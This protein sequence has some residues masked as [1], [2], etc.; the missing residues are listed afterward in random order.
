VRRIINKKWILGIIGL[1]L[2]L[3]ILKGMLFW[4][5]K[6]KVTVDYVA[7]YNNMARPKNYDPNKNAAEDYQKA[8]D[9]FIRMP[10]QVSAAITRPAL[11]FSS[12]KML[13][14]MK[15]MM[16]PNNIRTTNEISKESQSR[17]IDWPTDFNDSDQNALKQWLASN[18]PAFDYFRAAS[19]K[20]YYG[21]ERYT[22]TEGGMHSVMIPEISYLRD[23]SNAINWNAKKLASETKYESAFYDILACYR[24]GIH[25]CVPTY[26][27]AEQINGSII[28]SWSIA[29]L[30]SI[31]DRVE[32]GP[33]KLRIF[34]D[35]LKTTFDKDDY[36]P[37]FGAEKLHA[38]DI[39][40]QIFVYNKKGTGRPP[41][42]AVGSVISSCGDEDNY[43]I[44]KK[45]LYDCLFGPTTNEMAKIIEEKYA[46][47]ESAIKE[48]PW[49]LYSMDPAFLNKLV[50]P[51]CDDCGSFNLNDFFFPH[52]YSSHNRYYRLKA[53]ERALLAIIAIHRFKLGKGKLPD[54]LDELVAA[55]Y[56]Q[57]LPLDPYSDGALVYRVEGENFT[58][59]SIGENFKDDG[60]KE[61]KNPFDEILFWPVK[62]PEKTVPVDH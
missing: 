43:K 24:V 45:M 34:Q 41:C 52:F 23:M 42:S 10:F 22:K 30:I 3:L 53:Q 60:G 1:L 31:I 4:T 48:T 56:L 57:T 51:R 9:A 29:T 46:A 58:L 33:E 21:L 11:E 14:E 49:R 27:D 59:Y 5:A 35:A 32:I 28:K 55:G 26:L 36:I 20:P 8:F 19:Q 16:D 6:P 50:V 62:R 12:K 44:R 2:F 18:A 7:E 15:K 13:E 47:Y 54:K 40:Q 25:K 37:G 38:Y 39:L 61:T 17:R